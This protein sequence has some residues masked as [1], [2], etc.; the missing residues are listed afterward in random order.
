MQAASDHRFNCVVVAELHRFGFDLGDFHER[1]QRLET[2]GVRFVAAA[3]HIDTAQ[4][5][6]T[7]GAIPIR[8]GD[9]LLK[10]AGACS[11]LELSEGEGI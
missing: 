3:Q 8:V 9:L 4:L 6:H 1:L 5:V 11:D 2:D 7:S 10:V